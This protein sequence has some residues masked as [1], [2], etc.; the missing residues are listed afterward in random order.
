MATTAK[1]EFTV[2]NAYPYNQA[3]APRW[4]FSHIWRYK[5]LFI[6]AIL[7]SAVDFFSYSQSSV[8]IG[9][10]AAEILHPRGGNRLLD[11]SL[12]VLGVMTLS[13]MAFWTGGLLIE[14]LA[15]RLEADSRQELYISL[16]GKSQTFHDRQRVGDIMARAT[17]D[18]RQLNFMLSPG[19]RFI[20][21]T[22]MGLAVPLFYIATIRYQLLLVPAIFIVTYAVSVRGYTRRLNPI[23][24]NQ[25]EQFGTLNAG[26]EEVLSGIEVVKASVQ[27]TFE[28]TR[29]R[30][31]ARLFRD[32]FVQQGQTEARYL[33][34][35]LFGIALGFTFLH[36]MI[37]YRR[38]TVSLPDII[39]VMGLMNVLRFPVFI[40]IFSFS[41]VQLGLAGAERILHIIKAET[42][43][44]ENAGGYGQ[45][46][47]GGITFENVT[48]S[49]EGQEDT[50][51]LQDISFHITPGQTVAIVGET[52]SGK[53]TLAMLIN[54]TYDATAGRILIDGAG[55]A[56]MGS[57]RAP[58]ANLED[59]AGRV[60][61]LAHPGGEYRVWRAGYAAGAHRTGGARSPGA[62]L[63][64]HLRRRLPDEGWRTRRDAVRR[65]APTYRP[66]ARFPERPAHPDSG[67][68]DQR[69][70]QRHRGRNSE[71][72]PP[73]AGRPHDSADH[74]PDVTNP[75]GGPDPGAGSWAIGGSRNARPTAA[76]VAALP[77]HFCAL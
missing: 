66:G 64:H 69:H 56:R 15:Q 53:S 11:L 38:G 48:F 19:L 3:S 17:D 27:E 55:R 29:F 34:L 71:S 33:P 4:V 54:R 47:Q 21:E 8:L 28:R 39:A 10:A 72:H 67:R 24:R 35:L 76:H 63:H 65:S 23:M 61:V 70:R 1:S 74:P 36:A 7:L 52:G 30:R 9:K 62:R 37:L 26:L 18:V 60:F 45:P 2:E 77:A 58:L 57:D 51:V 42:E 13:S 75:L 32:Y 6:M 31:N 44:D 12:G 40:S 41:L 46:I 5:W 20:Y 43:L 59:R 49:Y 73:R 68:L 14:T 50:P 16:L 22:V 25:R